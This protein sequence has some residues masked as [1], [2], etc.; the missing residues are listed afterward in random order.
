MRVERALRNARTSSGRGGSQAATT[1]ASGG[2]RRA[3]RS[4]DHPN[5]SPAQV[6]P[7]S[8]SVHDQRGPS[9][10][11]QTASPRGMQQHAEGG[12]HVGLAGL[13]ARVADEL[14]AGRRG[15]D[16]E[17]TDQRQQQAQVHARAELVG[18]A[19]LGC[20]PPRRSPRARTAPPA[21]GTAW[22]PTR[23][24]RA[25]DRRRCPEGRRRRPGGGA[26]RAAP[27]ATRRAGR[28]LPG[29]RA[30]TRATAPPRSPTVK[31]ALATVPRR[32]R[33]SAAR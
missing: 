19:A 17:T 12:H 32:A 28:R 11:S 31:T 27:G 14:E 20:S 10:P 5:D 23:R 1:A 21:R 33:R 16:G 2:A 9:T 7:T 25:C 18:A 26:G 3:A 13:E 22:R 24:P 29:A 15:P 8:R 6:L 4:C 30:R